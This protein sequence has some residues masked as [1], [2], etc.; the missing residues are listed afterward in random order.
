M[1]YEISTSIPGKEWDQYVTSHV[2]GTFFHLN[3]WQQII[4]RIFKHKTY[5][6]GAYKNNKLIG[7][8]PLAHIKSRIFGNYVSSLPFCTTCGV[9]ADSQQTS[10]CLINYAIDLSTQ[11]KVDYL[12][13][14]NQEIINNDWK[15]KKL[16]VEFKKNISVDNDEN[17]KGIPRKQRAVIRKAKKQG[18]NSKQEN[19]IDSFYYAYSNSVRNLGTPVFSKKYFQE[20]I[21]Q[22]K[23]QCRILT[24]YKEDKIISSVMSFYYKDEVLPYYGGGASIARQ[25]YA[26]DFMYWELM[27]RSSQENIRVFNYGRSKINTGSYRFKKHWGF[28]P[29]PLHYQYKLLNSDDI[30]DLSPAN[31]KY[32]MAIN[33]WKHL[34]LFVTNNLGPLVSRYLG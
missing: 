20:L 3:A 23:D 17:L 31:P 28:E 22:F 34:P 27:R 32:K 29:L 16:Y 33:L 14:R 15:T 30:P 24:I 26:N 6:V 1:K 5:Y 21:N 25:L 18:L 4:H 13:L 19:N 9:L 12:E 2:R 11:Q 8:L 10:E 7:I